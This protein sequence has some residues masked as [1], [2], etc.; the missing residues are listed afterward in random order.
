MEGEFSKLRET[1]RRKRTNDG[2]MI[3]VFVI[4]YSALFIVFALAI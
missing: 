1:A 2:I 4:T 3:S